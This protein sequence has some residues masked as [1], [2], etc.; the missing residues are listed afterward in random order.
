MTIKEFRDEFFINYD[1]ASLGGPSLNNYEVSLFLTQAVRDIVSELYARF[2]HTEFNKRA[3]APLIKEN[4]LVLTNSSDYFPGF[5]AYRATLPTELYYILQENAILESGDP[6]PEVISED[7]DNLNRVMRNPFRRPNAKKVIRTQI[8]KDSIRIH[9]LNVLHSFKVKYIKR[10]EPLIVSNFTTDPE[11]VG[12]E[13][14]EGKN[15]E[16]LTDLPASVHDK[17]VKR[18]VQLAIRSLRENTLKTQIEV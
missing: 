1:M 3:L 17:I 4:S 15:T 11:L 2:E 13:T 10:P 9:T 16:T 12:T 18:A 8:S 5:L 6:I 14:I 7:L